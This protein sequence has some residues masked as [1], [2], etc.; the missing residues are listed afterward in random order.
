MC[1]TLIPYLCRIP[2]FTSPAAQKELSIHRM[3][4]SNHRVGL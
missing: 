3:A 4:L 1:A 2:F